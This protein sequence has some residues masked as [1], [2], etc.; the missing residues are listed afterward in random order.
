MVFRGS[1]KVKK[2]GTQISLQ[3]REQFGYHK[4]IR[5]ERREFTEVSYISCEMS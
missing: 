2:A 5:P 3:H 4:I 1:E